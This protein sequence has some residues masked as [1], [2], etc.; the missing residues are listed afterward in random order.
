[1]TPRPAF[2]PTC[3]LIALA[4]LAC[5]AGPAELGFWFEPVSFTSSAT[6]PLTTHDLDTIA[7]VARDE[8]AAAFRGYDVRL[9][10]RRDATYRVRVIQEIRDLRFKSNR[11]G[12]AGQSF[13]VRG[14]GG[15][16]AVNFTLLASNAVGYAPAGAPRSAIVDAI[17][18][19]VARAAV[20]EFAHQLLP[21]R[22]IDSPTD[23]D[24]YEYGYAGRAQQ[25]WGTLRWS[26]A[27]PWLDERLGQRT[28]RN[29]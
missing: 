16:G 3:V 29:R 14:F 23:I 2:A 5:N 22:P 9:S 13:A 18:R 8:L 1:M 19:G 24:S 21:D 25:Y 15:S 17:G 26:N 28:A 10:D 12:P 20:H 11:G 7:A 4:A 6:G 27:R